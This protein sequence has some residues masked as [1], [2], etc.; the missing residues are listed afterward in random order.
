MK[1]LE[2]RYELTADTQLIINHESVDC[3]SVVNFGDPC[4]GML[5][6]WGT[7]KEII[8]KLRQIADLIEKNF[9]NK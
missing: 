9:N 2:T 4:S 1:K 6:Q 8:K 7:R 5:K 3:I